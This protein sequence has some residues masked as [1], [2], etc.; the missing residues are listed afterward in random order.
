MPLKVDC[1]TARRTE[2]G[3]QSPD[4]GACTLRGVVTLRG[5]RSQGNEPERRRHTAVFSL[6][7]YEG[8]VFFSYEDLRHELITPAREGPRRG[9]ELRGS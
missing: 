3:S 6:A 7:V 2:G 4:L 9:S 5:E 1:A 8:N